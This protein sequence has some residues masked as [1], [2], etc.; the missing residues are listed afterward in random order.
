MNPNLA[1]SRHHAEGRHHVEGR[2]H[3]EG[4]PPA[5]RLRHRFYRHRR[6]CPPPPVQPPQRSGYPPLPPKPEFRRHHRST[7]DLETEKD[8][9]AEAK[10]SSGGSILSNI[11]NWFSSRSGE[12]QDETKL[13]EAGHD[14]QGKSFQQW[15]ADKERALKRDEYKLSEES[16]GLA[17][18]LSRERLAARSHDRSPKRSRERLPSQEDSPV[19]RELFFEEEGGPRW[20]IKYSPRRSPS[21]VDNQRWTDPARTSPAAHGIGRHR[22]WARSAH[23]EPPKRTGRSSTCTVPVVLNKDRP[24]RRVRGRRCEC[25]RRLHP[26]P[27][28]SKEFTGNKQGPRAVF[29]VACLDSLDRSGK[30]DSS[31]RIERG[32]VVDFTDRRT[33]FKKP[34][35]FDPVPGTPGQPGE[36]EER[37]P[38]ESFKHEF[39][40]EMDERGKAATMAPAVSHT[41]GG[42]TEAAAHSVAQQMAAIN[43]LLAHDAEQS[44]APETLAT[45][46]VPKKPSALSAPHTQE[47]KHSHPGT[48]KEKL[49]D[50]PPGHV[51][52]APSPALLAS[53]SDPAGK[54]AHKPHKSSESPKPGVGGK[55]ASLGHVGAAPS[56]A[57]LASH[58]EP[59]G[60]KAHKPHKSS[61]SPKPGVG[62]KKAS[63]SP[64]EPA[65]TKLRAGDE[66]APQARAV[67]ERP[68]VLQVSHGA[69]GGR[70]RHHH[71]RAAARPR[72]AR[73]G[74]QVTLASPEFRRVTFLGDSIYL[75]ISANPCLMANAQGTPLLR[76]LLIVIM[77]G[78][79]FVPPTERSSLGAAKTRPAG[80]GSTR[81][82]IPEGSVA[83]GR[84]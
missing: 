72:S 15:L 59:A 64:G 61:E 45:T 8:E 68:A 47:R 12:K 20:V 33:T 77:T 83:R 38:E 18:K 57:L 21:L 79:T 14:R 55:K 80:L 3:A 71:G 5:F 73:V 49:H 26:W 44:K 16:I 11:F 65:H 10:P 84:A 50:M 22:S 51:G 54:K 2:H 39:F 62:G 34:R 76:V 74:A 30:T 1:R 29:V 7:E 52:A 37:G 43:A 66:E 25:P 17:G 81:R 69:R 28:G 60:K 46:S 48:S 58:S 32:T 78:T 27:C 4:R 13:K 31:G 23:R 6:Y 36:E 67:L 19:P 56:P 42:S 40:E 9:A 53:H 82:F 35:E 24:L 75:Y 63:L 41:G 70:L